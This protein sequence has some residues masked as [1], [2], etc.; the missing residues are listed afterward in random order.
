MDTGQIQEELRTA[1]ER[2]R[3]ETP[4]A[5]SITNAVTMNFV[6]NAQLAVGGSA[7][8]VYL[9][10][11]A[12]G[13]AEL[14]G[15]FYVNC[16]TLLPPHEASI[17]AVAA[18]MHELGK[19]LVL[20]PVGIGL[21]ALRASVLRRIRLCK[22]AI[23]R[24]NASEVIALAELWGLDTG[25]G[26]SSGPVG[27]DSV[28]AVED[29]RAA[30]IAIARFTGGVVAVSGEADTVTDGRVVATSHGGS[31]MMKAITGMGCSQGGVIAIYATAADPLVAALAGV[32]VYN[33]AGRRAAE[34]SGGTGTMQVAFLDELSKATAADIAGNPFELEEA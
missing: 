29:A 14:G 4:L 27:V 26:G 1:A 13:L 17:P 22:P 24:G 6:A 31:E 23:V 18:K 30:A 9:A 12:E 5:G 15:A 21:G 10:D 2:V 20:D 25:A 19:P 32:Q 7:A 33:L 8:M 16:G 28:D 11:E 34:R 3:A